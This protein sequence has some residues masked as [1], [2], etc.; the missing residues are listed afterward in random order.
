MGDTGRVYPLKGETVTWQPALNLNRAILGSQIVAIV[1]FVML[2]SVISA[3]A[4]RLPGLAAPRRR[5][6]RNWRGLLCQAHRQ[7]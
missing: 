2:R 6:A 4:V 7:W 3:G 5:S 1:L